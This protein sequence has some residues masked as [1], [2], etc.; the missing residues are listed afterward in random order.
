M[1]A[2]YSLSNY[3]ETGPAPGAQTLAAVQAARDL[4]HQ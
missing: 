4:L 1:V 2:K 3:G